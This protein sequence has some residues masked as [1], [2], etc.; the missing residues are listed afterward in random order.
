ME[1]KK[2][3]GAIERRY[4]D[5]CEVKLAGDDAGTFSGYGAVFNNV[6]SYGDVIAPGAFAETL[7]EWQAKGKFPPMLL[8]HGGFGLG[9]DDMLP[10]GEWTH[11]EENSRGLKMS[12]RLFALNTE[13]GQ[14]IYEG[15]K[16]G[17]LDGLSIGFMVKEATNGTKPGE[18]DRLLTKIDL[19]E[20][21]IVTFPAN[22]KAR[23]TGVKNLTSEDLR[24]L[25]AAFR[26]EGLSRSDAVT[27]VSGFRKWCQRD[28][29]TSASDPR[30][31]DAPDEAV[32]AAQELLT[33][34][35]VG[36][37]KTY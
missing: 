3:P 2:T 19:W 37:V 18:P 34:F 35:C 7:Q 26:D 10:V 21:S 23:V 30:D 15:L 33:R 17:A 11:M 6:D 28:A 16:A 8:Q 27:A 25:E 9:A 1:L 29:G 31:G 4:V 5:L 36:A 22:P 12:G 32:L 14:Y 13:R 20:V 24:E